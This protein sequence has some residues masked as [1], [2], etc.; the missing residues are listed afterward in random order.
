MYNKTCLCGA[1]FSEAASKV[2]LS[3]CDVPCSGD[4]ELSCGGDTDYALVYAFD[5]SSGK[6][7]PRRRESVKCLEDLECKGDDG[8]LTHDLSCSTRTAASLPPETSSIPLSTPLLFQSRNET[9]DDS[10]APSAAF[11]STD[12]KSTVG[13]VLGSITA[14]GALLAVILF[15]IF[16]RRRRQKP[17]LKETPSESPPPP[18]PP[19]LV[20]NT[21]PR[22]PAP[23][24]ASGDKTP[25]EDA[26]AVS[27]LS[28][29][30]VND[31]HRA[32]HVSALASASGS[33]Q[34]SRGVDVSPAD[35]EPSDGAGLVVLTASH[36]VVRPVAGGVSIVDSRASALPKRRYS[37][38]VGVSRGGAWGWVAEAG[39]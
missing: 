15:I 19:P 9:A 24:H 39:V 10:L 28:A 17:T 23:T 6:E 32:S 27:P 13:M 22:P 21:E 7:P 2:D 11:S 8:L 34:P 29:A 3:L 16:L 30:N 1:K 18:L 31:N 33:R 25:E 20:T 14:A 38:P 37:M 35:T 36:V 4:A 26:L 12:T 5:D